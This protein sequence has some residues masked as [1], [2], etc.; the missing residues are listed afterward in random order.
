MGVWPRS[1]TAAHS[2]DRCLWA[3][4]NALVDHANVTTRI[5]HDG[6]TADPVLTIAIPTY[7]RPALLAEAVRSAAA[8]RLD[9][10]IEILVVDNDP[11]TLG[12]AAILE[13]APDLA[14][15]PVRYSVN[16]ENIGMLGNW[17]R[18][19]AMARGKWL[20]ILN[21]DDLLDPSFAA[22]MLELLASTGADG[23]VCG[24]RMLDER[25]QSEG[26]A[27]SSWTRLARVAAF[28]GRRTRRITAQRMFWGNPA[29]N[30]VGFLSRTALFRDIG[31]FYPEEY[32]SADYFLFARFALRFRLEQARDVLASIRVAENE[33]MRE[34]VLYGFLRTEYRIQQALSATVLPGWWRHVSPWLVG[35][36]AEGITRM[37]RVTLDPEQI[38][39]RVGLR[40]RPGRHRWLL[41]IRAMLGGF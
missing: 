33:S 38:R 24:K 12:W 29:G 13:I 3:F 31:G 32:P 6:V 16:V 35:Q 10:A 34:D 41:V 18:C 30:P 26:N 25:E 7:R 22:T 21:D 28:R 4:R 36:H 11:E 23:M 17:N 8:Q 27:I 5:V 15:A 14:S 1:N 20:T 37:W 39:Q 19:I 9:L 2:E 40:H